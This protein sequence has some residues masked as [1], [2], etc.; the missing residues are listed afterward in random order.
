MQPELPRRYPAERIVGSIRVSG[1]VRG[2]ETVRI[3]ALQFNVVKEVI[4][5]RQTD[6]RRKRQRRD[7]CPGRN[8]AIIGPVR[9]SARQVV[10]ELPPAVDLDSATFFL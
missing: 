8:G 3:G 9:H 5:R 7:Y 10:K 4:H 2:F 1:I 6:I